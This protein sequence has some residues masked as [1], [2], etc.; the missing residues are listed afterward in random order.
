MKAGATLYFERKGASGRLVKLVVKG[1][2]AG[3]TAEQIGLQS[4]DEFVRVGRKP[5][6]DLILSEDGDIGFRRG[7]KIQVRR[8]GQIITLTVPPR[9]KASPHFGRLMRE[10]A[11]PH[12]NI[13]AVLK[14]AY[15]PVSLLSDAEKER[16][17]GEA[18]ARRRQRRAPLASQSAA[19]PLPAPSRQQAAPAVSHFQF[20]SRWREQIAGDQLSLEARHVADVVAA[21]YVNIKPG[22]D[23]LCAWPS[24]STL[25]R[26]VRKSKT[27]VA[28]AVKELAARGH[29]ELIEQ[30]GRQS[31]RMRLILK[32][33]ERAAPYVQ[34][35]EPAKLAIS[36]LSGDFQNENTNAAQICAAAPDEP[37]IA[38]IFNAPPGAAVRV[39]SSPHG[40]AL[41]GALRRSNVGRQVTPESEARRKAK[42]EQQEAARAREEYIDSLWRNQAGGGR[43]ESDYNPLAYSSRG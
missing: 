40:D 19:L 10:L 4:G 14:E 43:F 3:T 28:Q 9:S 1:F 38:P 25:R 29:I 33:N 12:A 16:L 30:R 15:S 31:R 42:A 27:A 8:A 35:A 6:S 32:S 39:K 7:Q 41:M 22:K 20:L 21:K 18:E 24:L 2:G 34:C 37:Q 11:T 36:A 13:D 26:A 5:I 17:R 23:Y